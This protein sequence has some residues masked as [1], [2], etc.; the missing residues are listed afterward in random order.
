MRFFHYRGPAR[1]IVFFALLSALR[2]APAGGAESAAPPDPATRPD[3]PEMV[4]VPG[5]EFQMG[6]D[7]SSDAAPVHRVRVSPFHIDKTEV[8]NAEYRA[9][10]EATGHDLPEFWGMD[11]FRS[12]PD[13]PNH[14]VVGVSW[15]DAVEYAEWRGARLPTEAEW[16]YAARGGLGGARYAFGDSLRSDMYAPTGVVGDGGPSPVASFPPNGFGL[17]D[18][19]GNVNEWV[20]DRYDPGY[21]ALSP[22]E[23]PPGPAAGTFRVFRGAGWHT[24]P[25][26]TG[27]AFRNALRSNWLDFNLGFRCAK[28]A[29]ASAA[30]E[31]EKAFADS[32][33]GGG[34]RRAWEM[35]RAEPGAFYFDEAELKEMG[36]RLV[37]DRRPVEALEVCLLTLR[38]FPESAHAHAA[39]AEAYERVGLRESAVRHYEKAL[40]LVP[41]LKAAREALER[42]EAEKESARPGL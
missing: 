21:Y 7:E 9:F 30:L 17:H 42:F 41:R 10:C 22:V 29:G 12:G 4:L 35:R 20:R 24:G 37:T 31:M 6:D 27:V 25:G 40:E 28:S 5:G 32:G 8:T 13:F 15:G 11:V 26:C 36:D 2:A 39:L 1:G 19:T 3:G 18:M 14:P 33:L 23:D 16:E 38:L 34:I